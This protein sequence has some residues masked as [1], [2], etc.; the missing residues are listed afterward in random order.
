MREKVLM[1][2]DIKVDKKFQLNIQDREF[3]VVDIDDVGSG[4]EHQNLVVKEEDLE[5]IQQPY[6][7]TIKLLKSIYYLPTVPQKID[8]IHQ[9]LKE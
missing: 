2:T 1:L 3:K 5:Q 7:K 9:A 6:V 4:G 8:I